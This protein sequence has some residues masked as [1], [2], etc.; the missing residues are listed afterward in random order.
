LNTFIR[1]G[2]LDDGKNVVHPAAYNASE[3]TRHSGFLAQDVEKAAKR[4]GYDFDG[5]LT[6]EKN[7]EKYYSL[8]YSQFVVPLV[9]A[10]Q[11]LNAENNMLKKRLNDLEVRLSALE[12]K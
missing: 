3:N 4:I 10:V 9:K 6:P 5:V 12:K 11:E 7:A 2:N 1:T 8:S